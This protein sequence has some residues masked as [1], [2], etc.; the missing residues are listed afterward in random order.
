MH[1]EINRFAIERLAHLGGLD[2][3]V[4]L[5]RSIGLTLDSAVQGTELGQ[6]IIRGG[7]SE[8]EPVLRS[9]HHF[10]DPTR[11]AG[12]VGVSAASWAL[13]T[14]QSTW[15]SGSLFGGDYSWPTANRCF[16]KG[17]TGYEYDP[18]S[19]RYVQVAGSPAER[20]EYLAEAFRALGQVMH[21]VADRDTGRS[22]S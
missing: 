1:Q 19:L 12:L 8:D 9:M 22:R 20:E 3:N 21:L 5:E 6:R 4:H 16:F 18:G 15:P 14:V 13:G 10:H 17:L 2:L 11:D 7:A